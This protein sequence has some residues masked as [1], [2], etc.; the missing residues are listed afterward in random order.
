MLEKELL[1]VLYSNLVRVQILLDGIS[2][3]EIKSAAVNRWPE[4]TQLTFSASMYVVD[5]G[6]TPICMGNTLASTMRTFLRPYTLNRGS[7]TPLGRKVNGTSRSTK[8]F[9]TSK[10]LWCH[11]CGSNWVM[12]RL[13]CMNS[14]QISSTDVTTWHEPRERFVGM[15]SIDRQTIH[16]PLVEEY[17]ATLWCPISR[18]NGELR[19]AINQWGDK[20]TFS[21][22]YQTS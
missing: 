7:T 8:N 17:Q 14:S 12:G 19:S 5:D 11:S 9:L 16:L 3:L 15:Q 6:A 22:T 4:A 1:N 18:P 10:L 21:S 20:G 2:R 13:K